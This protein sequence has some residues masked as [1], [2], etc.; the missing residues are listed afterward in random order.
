MIAEK[1]SLSVMVK[2]MELKDV[3]SIVSLIFTTIIAIFTFR[4]NSEQTELLLFFLF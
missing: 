3:I 4:L 2:G 1:A